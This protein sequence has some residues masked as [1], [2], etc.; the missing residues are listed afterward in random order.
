MP[1][2]L[3]LKDP[4]YVK[5]YKTLSNLQKAVEGFDG[6]YV[7]LQTPEGRYYAMFIGEDMA[8]VVWSG[9]AVTN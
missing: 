4:R 9:H 8:H 5:T 2:L 7:A 6:K 1:K 3:N